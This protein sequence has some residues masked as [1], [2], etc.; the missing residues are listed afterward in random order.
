MNDT[1]LAEVSQRA[2]PYAAKISTEA[3]IREGFATVAASVRRAY[4]DANPGADA[5]LRQEI[6]DLLAPVATALESADLIEAYAAA[7]PC[8]ET[9][10]ATELDTRTP[11]ERGLGRVS[12][13]PPR[14]GGAFR[15]QLSSPAA[16]HEFGTLIERLVFETYGGTAGA[17]QAFYETPT[18]PRVLP[19]ERV[20]EVW[21]PS[22]HVGTRGLGEDAM[23]V[24]SSAHRPTEAALEPAAERHGL[25]GGFRG[26]KQKRTLFEC[27]GFW[28]AAG[29]A[30]YWLPATKG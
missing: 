10:V 1:R 4:F 13:S 18:F 23:D 24:I 3:E 22:V 28:T 9:F 6:E 15:K 25:L 17:L 5:E 30:L 12:T 7:V 2:E 19:A 27:A 20:F 16:R 29:A 11:G 14:L 21:V 26:G 8:V